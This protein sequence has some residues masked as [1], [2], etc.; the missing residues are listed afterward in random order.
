MFAY[1]CD[2]LYLQVLSRAITENRT[3]PPTGI[4]SSVSEDR[5]SQRFYRIE[6]GILLE[7]IAPFVSGARDRKYL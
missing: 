6:T 2:L 4:V 5:A 1:T 3:A 7:N